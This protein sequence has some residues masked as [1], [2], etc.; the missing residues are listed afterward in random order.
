MTHITDLALARRLERC[1]GRAN[2][3]FVA[4]RARLEP[5]SGAASAVTDDAFAMFDGI[6]SPITQ[7]FGLGLDS[8][9]DDATL[10]ALEAFFE[11]R[12]ADVSHETTP[13]ADAGLPAALQARGYRV[14]EYSSVLHAPMESLVVHA[15]PGDITVRPIGVGE[16]ERWSDTSAAGWGETP[17]L[18]E[19]IRG[20]GR[21]GAQAVG[22][23]AF[24]AEQDG[25]AMGTG[26]L[27][28]HDGVALLA[29]AS[30]PPAFRRRG[31]QAALLAARIAYARAA[32]CDLVMMAAAPGSTSQ[33]N[34]ERRGLR[35]A[36]TRVKWQRQLSHRG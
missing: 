6:G 27:G 33:C 22:S 31:V 15:A 16:V 14:I 25:V 26:A 19:F 2:T 13:L 12:G 28:M 18:A 9:P 8:A 29:G 24:I 21:I 5:A 3:E 30:T 7:T 4:A 34:A 23:T 10:T 11:S 35:V 20:Y 32:G 1:E 36:Y 17:E